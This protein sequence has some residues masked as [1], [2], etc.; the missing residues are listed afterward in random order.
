MQVNLPA[1]DEVLEEVEF[2]ERERTDRHVVEVAILLDDC[3]VSLRR[4]SQ[5][6]GWLGVERSH[7]VVWM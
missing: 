6:L 3:G 7:V 2:F 4:G 5:V 1:L